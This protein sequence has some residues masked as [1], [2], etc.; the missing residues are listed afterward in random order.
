MLK[1]ISKGETSIEMSNYIEMITINVWLR[2]R[3]D[4]KNITNNKLM[5]ANVRPC[6]FMQ[7]LA[8][9]KNVTCSVDVI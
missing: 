7:Q 6:G 4:K 9:K 5:Q 3:L 8:R 2:V 1:H